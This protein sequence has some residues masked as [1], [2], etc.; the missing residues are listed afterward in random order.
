M[1]GDS[2]VKIRVVAMQKQF[3]QVIRGKLVDVDL[4]LRGLE[5]NKRSEILNGG[6]L[7]VL[8]S[9]YVIDYV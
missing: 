3:P 8:C 5:V 9:C 2:L 4:A 1:R 6:T 7:R